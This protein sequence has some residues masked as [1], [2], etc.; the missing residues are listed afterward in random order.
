M[1]E[2]A[3]GG[4]G[5]ADGVVTHPLLCSLGLLA[6]STDQISAALQLQAK[7]EAGKELPQLDAAALKLQQRLVEACA[8]ANEVRSAC[9]PCRPLCADLLPVDD[10]QACQTK[11]NWRA[12]V[13][14]SL[15]ASQL[16][17]C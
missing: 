15:S 8:Q 9:T 10:P 13:I 14:G 16:P 1:P 4:A 6:R 11:P 7:G 2:P 3:S 5:A 17:S 12:C